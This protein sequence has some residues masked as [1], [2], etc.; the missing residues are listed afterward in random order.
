MQRI[1]KLKRVICP[2]KTCFREIEIQIVTKCYKNKPDEP[3]VKF[4]Q[5]PRCKTIYNIE[6]NTST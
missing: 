4:V 1:L 3:E 6:K 2:K 5:C